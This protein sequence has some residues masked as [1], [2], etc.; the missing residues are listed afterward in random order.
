M[1][2]TYTKTVEGLYTNIEQFKSN[3]TSVSHLKENKEDYNNN[4]VNKHLLNI[5]N[6]QSPQELWKTIAST[7]IKISNDLYQQSDNNTKIRFINSEIKD[8][9]I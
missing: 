9:S 8:L 7:C 3:A 6:I 1:S 4:K 5:N 2:S